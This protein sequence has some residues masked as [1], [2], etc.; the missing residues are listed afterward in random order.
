M[1]DPKRIKLIL[2]ALEKYW[3]NNP[4]L[5]LCQIIGNL[6]QTTH[7]CSYCYGGGMIVYPGY[8]SKCMRCLGS[9]YIEL[10]T[11]NVEDDIIL[12]KLTKL[13]EV[14]NG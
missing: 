11:Y 12:E 2:A 14:A 6:L 3:N 1:R 7:M 8:K 13:N 9:G 5:R 4:D 10:S